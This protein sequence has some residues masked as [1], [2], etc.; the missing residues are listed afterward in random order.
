M[1]NIPGWEGIW[2]DTPLIERKRMQSS[3]CFGPCST[4]WSMKLPCLCVHL[5]SLCTFIFIRPSS[6]AAQLVVTLC[7]ST[8]PSNHTSFGPRGFACTFPG[9]TFQW[10]LIVMRFFCSS[11]FCCPCCAIPPSAE[12]MNY[13]ADFG[14][15]LHMVP[16]S[17]SWLKSPLLP[18][19]VQVLQSCMKKA[20]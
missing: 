20:Q 13:R 5:L 14:W 16:S 18:V 1:T 11:Y 7:V 2:A 10:E 3:G 6:L 17:Q 12:F 9:C 15:M 19:C 4:K 8:L